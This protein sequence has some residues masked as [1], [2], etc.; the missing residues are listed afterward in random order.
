MG[1]K[2]YRLMR[3]MTQEEVARLADITLKTYQNIEKRN[4]T[5][6]VTAKNISIMLGADTIEECFEYK[7]EDK[8]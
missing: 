2:E 8:K 3:G 6:I 5:N 4:N 1:L 7:E